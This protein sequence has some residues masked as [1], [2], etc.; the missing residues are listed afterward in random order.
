GGTGWAAAPSPLT[1]LPRRGEGN[2]P[3]L[4]KKA[5]GLELNG[6]GSAIFNFQFAVEWPKLNRVGFLQ[7]TSWRHGSNVKVTLTGAAGRLGSVASQRL[8]QSGFEVRAT[9]RREV[10]D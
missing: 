1:P 10:A 6:S 7:F 9:D 8:A 3:L 2:S 4:E 5:K